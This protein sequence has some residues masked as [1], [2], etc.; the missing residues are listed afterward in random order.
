M[1]E[2]LKLGVADWHVLQENWFE[3]VGPVLDTLF[4]VYTLH[5]NLMLVGARCRT[6]C[7]EFV[8]SV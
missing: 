2:I 5:G 7:G 1:K 8:N 6:V 3:A 4:Q